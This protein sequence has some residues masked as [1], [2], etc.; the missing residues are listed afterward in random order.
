MKKSNIVV[1]AH[2]A[3]TRMPRKILKEIKG[4]PML[5]RVLIQCSKA[6]SERDV[7]VATPDEE[8]YDCVKRWGYQCYMSDPRSPDGTSAIAS[9]S[10]KLDADFIINVQAD[11][12]LIPEDLIRML[13][14]NFVDS[15]ADIVTPVY[16]ITN[17][18]D[19][20]DIGVAKVVRDLDGWALYFSRNTIPYV[21]DVKFNNWPKEVPYW[22]H[23]GIYGYKKKVLLKF[24]KLRKSYLETA[25]RLEQ[26]RFLQNGI[27]IFTFETESR[28]L[29]VDTTDD[30]KRILKYVDE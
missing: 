7:C 21:R 22:G 2:L 8:I 23:Y 29:A 17:V 25:E 1:P 24:H 14:E 13:I 12:P 30:L 16:R 27:K 5:K 6:V 20:K 28:Q 11:Q 3:S 18:E 26:L 15:E 9:I 10:F 4:T 19:I